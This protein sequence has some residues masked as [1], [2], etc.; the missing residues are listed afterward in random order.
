MTGLSSSGTPLRVSKCQRS[1][2]T[3]VGYTA[4]RGAPRATNLLRPRGTTPSL[5]GT[6]L[7]E[8]NFRRSKGTRVWSI[9]SRGARATN[10]LQP[11]MIELRWSGTSLLVRSCKLSKGHA[12]PV[13][14]VSLADRRCSPGGQGEHCGVGLGRGAGAT[15]TARSGGTA[16]AQVARIRKARARWGCAGITSDR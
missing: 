8:R 13:K 10:S 3:R 12:G 4:S 14:K 9:V 5:S 2:G 16:R 6:L 15:A 1:K 7:R 11:Q